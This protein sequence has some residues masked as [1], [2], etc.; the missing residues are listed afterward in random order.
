MFKYLTHNDINLWTSVMMCDDVKTLLYLRNLF[1]VYPE[2]PN[3]TSCHF[4]E[5][6]I[7]R[8]RPHGV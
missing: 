2:S 6:T 5:I 8:C 7:S 3:V 4:S 1:R